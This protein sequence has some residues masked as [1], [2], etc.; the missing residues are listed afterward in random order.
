MVLNDIIKPFCSISSINT[1]D[2]LAA[3]AGVTPRVRVA[4][5]LGERSEAS[6]VLMR[7]NILEA[8]APGVIMRE[9]PGVF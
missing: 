9:L 2:V 3:E 5:L 8:E 6:P 7:D 4:A 1:L